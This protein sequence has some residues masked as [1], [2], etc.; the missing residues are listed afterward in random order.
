MLLVKELL[1]TIKIIILKVLEEENRIIHREVKVEIIM[2]EVEEGI[3]VNCVES[4]S[5]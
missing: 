3:N 5:T 2:V 1:L 4:L